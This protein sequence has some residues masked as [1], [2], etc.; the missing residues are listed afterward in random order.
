MRLFGPHRLV[1]RT[2]CASRHDECWGWG[3]G[4]L[5]EHSTRHAVLLQSAHPHTQRACVF[6]GW[7]LVSGPSEP[8]S[9]MTSRFP[10]F[11][12]FLFFLSCGT[13]CGLTLNAA[14]QLL[15]GG[16]GSA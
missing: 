14:C 2:H 1:A 4:A 5:E 11:F 6:G 8:H 15:A 7:C 13:R 12:P 3:H 16:Q 9:P 10:F